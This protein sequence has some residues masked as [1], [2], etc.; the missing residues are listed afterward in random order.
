MTAL[1]RAGG[2]LRAWPLWVLVLF[3]IVAWLG[4]QRAGRTNAGAAWPSLVHPLGIDGRGRDFVWVLV[5]GAERFVLPALVA[6]AALVTAVVVYVWLARERGSSFHALVQ[7]ASRGV[8][9]L[10]RFL[11]VLLVMM[12]L[13]EPDVWWMAAVLLVLYLPLALDE[14][15]VRLETLRRERVLLG[16]RAHGLPPWRVVLNHLALGHLRPMLVAHAAYLFVQVA[17]TEIAVAYVF[18]G[19]AIVPGL[20]TS[21]GV[22]LRQMM[23]RLPHPGSDPCL[24]QPPPCVASVESFQALTL[25]LVVALLLGGT[26]RVGLVARSRAGDRA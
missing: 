1:R 18:G 13:E 16:A 6:A 26:A 25:V 2:W 7:A 10:P 3:Q 24:G 20:A 8:G 5:H 14:A 23:G 15:S 9:T 17:L 21:W 22:E 11:V 19:S 4:G 12:A